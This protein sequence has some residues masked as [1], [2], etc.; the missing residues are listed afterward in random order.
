MS[1]GTLLELHT[2]ALSIWSI[3]ATCSRN[4]LTGLMS[5]VAMEL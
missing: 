1:M 5:N 3:V 2:T 4:G